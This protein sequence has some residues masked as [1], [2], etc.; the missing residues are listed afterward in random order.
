MDDLS[1]LVSMRKE[2]DGGAPDRDDRSQAVTMRDTPDDDALA[3]I[4]EYALLREL[5]GGGFGTVYLAKDTVSGVEYAVKGLPPKVK[6]SLEEVENIRT[7]FALVSRLSHTNIAR[8]HV[9]HRAKE[10]WYATEDVRE[11]LRVMP[12][13]TMMVMEYAP[14]V[15]L[16]KWRRQFPGGRVPSELALEITRQVAVALDY[17]HEQRVIHRDI[18]PSNVMVEAK[19]DDG[20]LIARV[21]DFGLAAEI[22]SSLGRVSR[23]VRDTS[24]TRPYMAPEQWLGEKQGAAAD[25]YALAVLF[26]ELVTGEVPFASALETGDVEVMK[27]VVTTKPFVAPAE[28][29]KTFRCVLKKALAKKSTERF[30]SCGEF[31]AALAGRKNG[32]AKA[33]LSA[34]CLAALAAGGVCLWQAR[35]AA[36]SG[37]TPSPSPSAGVSR[38]SD[39]PVPSRITS[40][41]GETDDRG[42]VVSRT[43]APAPRITATPIVPPPQKK[44]VEAKLAAARAHFARGDWDACVAAC[45]QALSSDPANAAAKA[46]KTDAERKKAVEA[47]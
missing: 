45:E 41:S 7:N 11:K 8:A 20:R 16:S 15:T 43:N 6:D 4:D 47:K 1:R 3:R 28:L 12:G 32:V 34:A 31:A 14:G 10:V 18:K 37:E 38:V 33:V 2:S 23:E 40:P 35:D 36:S 17:A 42:T 27:S 44:A 30:A 13:D 26:H 22:R 25:Q 29:P 39:N 24:G 21:L 46:C 5:G 19:P 9:L